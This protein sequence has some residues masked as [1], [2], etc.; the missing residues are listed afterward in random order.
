[1]RKAALAL[2]LA[3]TAGCSNPTG[4][5]TPIEGEQLFN[6]YCARCHGTDGAGVKEVPAALHRLSDPNVM[7]A[8]SDE[9]ILQTIKRGKPPGMPGFG[10]EFTDAKLM[11]IAAYVRT[12]SQPPEERTI[13]GKP[14][15]GE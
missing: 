6:Q 15:G 9:A 7:R 4:P 13:G 12:L 14:V 5:E 11:V 10:E 2:A 8:K 3:G 1:M